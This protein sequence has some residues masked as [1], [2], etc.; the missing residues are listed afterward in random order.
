MSAFDSK[1]ITSM[2]HRFNMPY[3]SDTIIA[4]AL[5]GVEF[6]NAF[7]HPGADGIAYRKYPAA[8]A[9]SRNDRRAAHS[10][11]LQIGGPTADY[12]PPMLSNDAFAKYHDRQGP[13]EPP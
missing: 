2:Q 8:V 11:P 12:K 7:F 3:K 13:R 5:L 6:C 9:C 1:K 4:S 10:L